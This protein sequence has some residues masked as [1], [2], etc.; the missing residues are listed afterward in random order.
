MVQRRRRCNPCATP[1]LALSRPSEHSGHHSITSSARAR[2]GCG[3][4]EAAWFVAHR[5]RKALEADTPAGPMGAKASRF[6]VDETYIGGKAGHKTT[7][8]TDSAASPVVDCRAPPVDF[9][10]AFK[11]RVRVR[12]GIMRGGRGGG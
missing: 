12:P 9:R 6:S 5:I 7:Y 11:H 8:P 4:V 10:N 1:S 2:E 3:I